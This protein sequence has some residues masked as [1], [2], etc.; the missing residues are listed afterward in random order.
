MHQVGTTDGSCPIQIS[1]TS[2][3]FEAAARNPERSRK[4]VHIG[5]AKHAPDLT[6]QLEP[7]GTG[8]R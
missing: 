2:P 7:L 6:S 3:L 1:V 8:L 5:D 4:V